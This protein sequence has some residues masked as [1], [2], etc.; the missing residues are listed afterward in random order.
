[1]TRTRSEHIVIPST[2]QYLSLDERLRY[3]IA[4]DVIYQRYTAAR[5]LRIPG[6]RA[7]R[8]VYALRRV[9]YVEVV[10]G[11][12]PGTWRNTMAGN[13]LANATAAAPISRADSQAPDWYRLKPVPF[14]VGTSGD[15]PL[16]QISE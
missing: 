12:P 6:E 10:P 2:A 3:N 15:P 4:I 5:V 9:G 7:R 14:P 1:V 16:N 11:Q 8:L 13:A